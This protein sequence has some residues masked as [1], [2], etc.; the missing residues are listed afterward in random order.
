MLNA[1]TSLPVYYNSI[2]E[3]KMKGN[4]ASVCVSC[5]GEDI[6]FIVKTNSEP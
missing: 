5:K 4:N 3:V 2:I 1:N 6:V